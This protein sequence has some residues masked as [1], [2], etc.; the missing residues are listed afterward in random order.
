MCVHCVYYCDNC[1]CR[2]SVG[3]SWTYEI[4]VDDYTVNF[5]YK[6]I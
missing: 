5:I 6:T 4:T 3:V 2:P 1:L